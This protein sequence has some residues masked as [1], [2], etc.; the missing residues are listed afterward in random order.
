MHERTWYF[1]AT[2]KGEAESTP[3]VPRTQHFK[4][5]ECPSPN[6]SNGWVIV[7]GDFKNVKFELKIGMDAMFDME[8]TIMI[9]KG[10][11]ARGHQKF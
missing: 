7:V 5:N 3:F 6:L 11:R 4:D 9:S 10:C 1:K 2:G 8:I